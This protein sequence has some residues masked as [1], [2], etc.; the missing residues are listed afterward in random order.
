MKGKSGLRK[1]ADSEEY[2]T[3]QQRRFAAA[4]NAR[5]RRRQQCP[6]KRRAKCAIAHEQTDDKADVVLLDGYEKL[7]F[8]YQ[9]FRWLSSFSVNA[10]KREDA[11][12]QK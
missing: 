11:E 1:L 3:V 10:K 12:N 8:V 5:V 6:T 2:V 9:L 7:A 4:A